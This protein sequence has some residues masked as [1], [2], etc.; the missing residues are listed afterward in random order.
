MTKKTSHF[1]FCL[2]SQKQRN[3]FTNR[4]FKLQQRNFYKSLCFPDKNLRQTWQEPPPD[5]TGTSSQ[6]RVW[7]L[8]VLW[9]II[10]VKRHTAGAYSTFA[11]VSISTYQKISQWILNLIICFGGINSSINVLTSHNEVMFSFC[12][13]SF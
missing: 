11:L 4:L 12:M 13:F 2:I 8:Q 9:E 7:N 3:G 5:M 6:N 10:N 1:M